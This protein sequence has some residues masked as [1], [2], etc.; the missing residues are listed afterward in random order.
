MAWTARRCLQEYCL[1]ITYTVCRYVYIHTHYS[2]TI[3]T[4]SYI[5]K[6]F[7]YIVHASATACTTTLSYK[8][9]SSIWSFLQFS[10]L[11]MQTWQVIA[12]NPQNDHQ[13][14]KLY[15]QARKNWELLKQACHATG[16]CQNV[17]R[18]CQKRPHP[19]QNL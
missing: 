8:S 2:K 10:R 12:V 19:T 15:V 1:V 5:Q 7:K 9:K 13:E 11:R 3:L 18:F 4:Y 6:S 16:P 14:N 17:Q